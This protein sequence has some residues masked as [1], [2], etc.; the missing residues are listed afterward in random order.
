MNEFL[1]MRTDIWRDV[2]RGSQSMKVFISLLLIKASK[3]VN[4]TYG[5]DAAKKRQQQNSQTE[6][7]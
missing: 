1:D 6:K 3:A 5:T 7:I 4:P 2:A